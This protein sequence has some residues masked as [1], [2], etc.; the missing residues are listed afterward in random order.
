[1]QKRRNM[2]KT[3]LGL[4]G[5]SAVATTANAAS[6]SKS[7][8]G[9]PSGLTVIFTQRDTVVDFQPNTGI[10]LQVGTVEGRISGTSLV[11]FQFTPLS[12]TDIKF[13]N[14][15]IITDLD[16]DQVIFKN[17]GTGKFIVPPLSDPSSPL[18]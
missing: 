3:L 1:M 4:G 7:A 5:L 10:G 12:Q 2:L 9:G 6:E 8:L 17:V 13:D 15:A 18:G 16:G 11:N 14:R